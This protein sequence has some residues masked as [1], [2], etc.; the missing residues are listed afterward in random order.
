MIS[1][2]NRYFWTGLL[3]LLSA[4]SG[5]QALKGKIAADCTYN[6][7]KLYGKIQFVNH[8]PDIKVKIVQHFEDLKVQ[9]VNHFPDQ[10]G[11]WLEVDHFPDLKVQ[12]VEHF[13]DIKIKYVDHW[14][15]L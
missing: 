14:P 11:K 15:G 8:F 4:G 2:H 7:K 13:E 12:I 10:C 1:T 3:L 6:G 5:P 9:K